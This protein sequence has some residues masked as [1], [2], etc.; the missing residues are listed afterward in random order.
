MRLEGL[1]NQ[2][3]QDPS[4]K[5]VSGGSR[6]EIA[7]VSG[8]DSA[9]RVFFMAALSHYWGR[10]VLI[11]TSETARAEKIY[12]DLTAFL[13]SGLVSLLPARELFMGTGV[14][15]QSMDLRQ[16]RLAFQEWLYHG[17]G[18]IFVAPVSALMSRV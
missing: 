18:G 15:S 4:F 10:P 17:K 1:L 14:L 12:E 5:A 8:L 11:V 2:W 13:P 7:V 9:A 16:Q 6:E 3:L